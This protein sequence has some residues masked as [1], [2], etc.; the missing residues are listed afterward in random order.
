MIITKPTVHLL[1]SFEDCQ[2]KLADGRLQAYQCP[3][4]KWTIGWG[5]TF[6]EDGSKVKEG[7]IITQERADKLFVFILN[8]FADMLK[9]KLANTVLKPNQFGAVLSFLY[10][11]GPGVKGVKAGL[12]ILKDGSPSTLWRLLNHNPNDPLIDKEF[13]KW[14]S[15]GSSFE[16]GLL[17]RRNAEVKLYNT[18]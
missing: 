11:V 10:N 6:Y 14:I 5:N 18:I 17:R 8:Q 4:K 2:K 13:V 7:D 1:H 16:K 9:K 15:A 12:F 3:A